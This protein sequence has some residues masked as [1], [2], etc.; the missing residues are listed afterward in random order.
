MHN[1]APDFILT[2]SVTIS[3]ML[4]PG[5]IETRLNRI[6]LEV[7]KPGRYAGGE[8]NSVQKN[9]DDNAARVTLIFPDIHE[10]PP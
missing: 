3:G 6:L 4:T 7:Q 1:S 9:W 10:F 8:L 5:E 2:N